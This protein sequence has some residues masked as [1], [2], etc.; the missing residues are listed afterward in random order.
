M[1]FIQFCL[2]VGGIVA[3]MLILIPKPSLRYF[4][5]DKLHRLRKKRDNLTNQMK[6]MYDGAMCCPNCRR[7][8]WDCRDDR[9]PMWT[10]TTMP[11]QMTCGECGFVSHWIDGPVMVHVLPPL[12]NVVVIE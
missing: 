9:G 3:L 4:Q 11:A 10:D 12:N 1:N 8:P 5:T 2:L 7:W 6:K